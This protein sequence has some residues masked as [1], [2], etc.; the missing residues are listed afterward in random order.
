MPALFSNM[1]LEQ[2][3]I[4][5]LKQSHDLSKTV[6][7]FKKFFHCYRPNIF[8]RLLWMDT[9][10]LIECQTGVTVNH[11]FEMTRKLGKSISF[12]KRHFQGYRLNI[13]SEFFWLVHTFC[14][15]WYRL[16]FCFVEYWTEV[17]TYVVL[18]KSRAV[19]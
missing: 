1:K 13:F 19:M 17:M 11:N 18:N 3:Q 9:C 4:T 5:A 10:I 15:L 7:L 12:F 8:S 6:I 2:L 16:P 14:D